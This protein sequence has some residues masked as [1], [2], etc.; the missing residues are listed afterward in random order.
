MN[1]MPIYLVDA[2]RVRLSPSPEDGDDYINANFVRGA[3]EQV[4]ISTQAP[5][6]NSFC[7]FWQMVWEQ[8]VH[9]IVMLTRLIESGCAKA[10]KYWPT[11]KPR[12]YGDKYRVTLVNRVTSDYDYRVKEFEVECEGERRRIVQFQ[13]LGWPDHGVPHSPDSLLHMINC[14]NEHLDDIKQAP[15]V[16]GPAPS[17]R[18][19][20]TESLSSSQSISVAS[21]SERSM[22]EAEPTLNEQIMTQERGRGLRRCSSSQFNSGAMPALAS[23]VQNTHIRHDSL[24]KPFPLKRGD[25]I[26][27]VEGTSSKSTSHLGSA[28]R[29][30]GARPFPEPVSPPTGLNTISP[31]S[32]HSSASGLSSASLVSS[33]NSAY[34]STTIASSSTVASGLAPPHYSAPITSTSSAP[35]YLSNLQVPTTPSNSPVNQSTLKPTNVSKGGYQVGPILVHCSAGIGRSGS[36][37]MIHSVLEKLA[38]EGKT[39]CDVSLKQLLETMREGREG[40]VPHQMQYNFCYDAIESALRYKRIIQEMG[41]SGFKGKVGRQNMQRSPLS[42]STHQIPQLSA[43]SSPP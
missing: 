18:T 21:G 3:G 9:V 39:M 28:L 10:H 31:S 30:F 41:I 35:F 6:P 42:R 23:L 43:D 11:S 27:T 7:D 25:S 2:T 20:E 29:G 15:F 26:G 38:A 5:M 36:F 17:P 19:V 14:I 1:G 22:T 33:T 13:F 4:Y 32:I 37:I 16:E 40:L 8:N 24:D 34:S 12:Q